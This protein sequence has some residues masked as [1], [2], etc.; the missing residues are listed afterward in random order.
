VFVQQPDPYSFACL[1]VSVSPYFLFPQQ[2]PVTMFSTGG[3]TKE[4]NRTSSSS[5][6]QSVIL[7]LYVI[8]QKTGRGKQQVGIDR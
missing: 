8:V 6:V 4:E 1:P 5:H 7:T 3:G 2:R